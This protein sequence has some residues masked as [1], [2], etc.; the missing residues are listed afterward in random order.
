M[1]KLLAILLSM[2]MCV[3]MAACGGSEPE[4]TEDTNPPVA[5]NT[6]N[7]SEENQQEE[8]QESTEYQYLTA[9]KVEEY[10][11][12][13]ANGEVQCVGADILLSFDEETMKKAID[14]MA[15]MFGE[16]DFLGL[17]AGFNAQEMDQIMTEVMFII[18]SASGEETEDPF[19][20]EGGEEF[21]DGMPTTMTLYNYD[22]DRRLVVEFDPDHAFMEPDWAMFEEQ[23]NWFICIDDDYSMNTLYYNRLDIPTE[24]LISQWIASDADKGIETT[25]TEVETFTAGGLEWEIFALVYDKTGSGIDKETGKEVTFTDTVYDITCFARTDSE[26]CIQIDAGTTHNPD[27]M[28][29]YKEIVQKSIKNIIVQ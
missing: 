3:S 5:E 28:N 26:S 29:N 27:I 11:Q 10:Y 21:I 23:S 2:V 20:S 17:L 7:V 8:I 19:A 15:M 6:E 12:M 14:A 25:A 16:E 24:E 9:D 4:G 13:I 22:L 18:N 1:K